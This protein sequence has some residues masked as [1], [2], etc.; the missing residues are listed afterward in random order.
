MHIGVF[1]A[2]TDFS[3][4][5]LPTGP[6]WASK[7]LENRGPESVW[8]SPGRPRATQGD[9]VALPESAGRFVGAFERVLVWIWEVWGRP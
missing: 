2:N 1:N 7:I 3:S 6:M 5:W 9:S 8:A 4:C